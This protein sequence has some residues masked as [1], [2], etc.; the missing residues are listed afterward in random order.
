[1]CH[2]AQ[3]RTNY[4]RCALPYHPHQYEVEIV[5]DAKHMSHVN[6]SVYTKVKC[7]I[8]SSMACIYIIIDY[9]MWMCNYVKIDRNF[10]I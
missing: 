5:R 4:Q 8:S 7:H 9:R 1:M 10:A 6:V 3:A 2:F